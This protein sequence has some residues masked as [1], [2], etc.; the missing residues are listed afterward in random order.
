MGGARRFSVSTPDWG[1]AHLSLDAIVAYVDDELSPSAH[2]RAQEH[3]ARC[4]E[5][6]AEVVAQRQARSALRAAGGPCLPSSLLRTLRAIPDDAELPPPPP[7]LSITPDGQ[8]VLLRDAP[9]DDI[10]TGNTREQHDVGRFARRVRLGALTGLA[11]GALAA[12]ALV[13][14]GPTSPPPSAVPAGPTPESAVPAR[15]VLGGSVLDVSGL[16]APAG[17]RISSAVPSD[18]PAAPAGPSAP[19]APPALVVEPVWRDAALK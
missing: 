7:G 9:R 15:A 19:S 5:C 10:P 17:V 12:G 16:D 4:D 1:Q 6:T 18:S 13:V 3:L 2:A 8:F 11:F 14:P